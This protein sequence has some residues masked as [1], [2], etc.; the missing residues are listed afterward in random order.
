MSPMC[1]C[2]KKSALDCHQQ[3]GHFGPPYLCHRL[4]R[5][6]DPGSFG[7]P[8]R[9]RTHVIRAPTAQ[10]QSFPT[11]DMPKPGYLWVARS[12][13]NGHMA[14]NLHCTPRGDRMAGSYSAHID[15]TSHCHYMASLTSAPWP[16]LQGQQKSTCPHTCSRIAW[17][18]DARPIQP[19]SWQAWGPLCQAST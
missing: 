12:E 17:I 7:K 16:C 5:S 15:L 4:S 18:A 14:S 10:N 9:C 19:Q 6:R 3:I 13:R 8:V 11:Q 2:A 1:L